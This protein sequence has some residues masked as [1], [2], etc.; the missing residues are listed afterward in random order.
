MELHVAGVPKP[1]DPPCRFLIRVPYAFG[2]LAGAQ[3]LCEVGDRLWGLSTGP[4]PKCILE[5]VE[6]VD[7]GQVVGDGGGR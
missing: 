4:Q 7:H 2:R 1:H 6:A 5:G 3:G